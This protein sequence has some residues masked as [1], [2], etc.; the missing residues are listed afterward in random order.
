MYIIIIEPEIPLYK[1]QHFAVNIKGSVIHDR[2]QCMQSMEGKLYNTQ[3]KETSRW[4]LSLADI[5]YTIGI[6]NLTH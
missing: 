4:P 3:K 1:L 6:M 2:M 5:N